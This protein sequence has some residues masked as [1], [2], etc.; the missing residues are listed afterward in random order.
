MA[1]FIVAH[2]VGRDEDSEA[3]WAR[4]HGVMVDPGD[5]AGAA[6]RPGWA[7]AC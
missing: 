7:S 6:A 1:H 3:I 2:F 4:G 5:V